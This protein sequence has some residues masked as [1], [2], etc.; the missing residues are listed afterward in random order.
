MATRRRWLQ[1]SIRTLLVLVTL[2]CVALGLW[3]VPAERQRRAV[4]AIEK[5]GGEVAYAKPAASETFPV[6][7]LR[8][9]LP[10]VYFDEVEGLYLGDTQVTD[11]GL[12]RLQGLTGLEILFLDNTP[13]TDA[14][15][16][17][18]QGLTTLRLLSLGDT[19]VTDAGLAHAQGLTGL[20]LLFLDN[21]QVTD[22]G[23]AEL[24]KALPNCEIH[25]P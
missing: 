3:C 24:H 19:Q 17:R 22:A 14:G 11:A 6:P 21:T 1:F 9:W 15:L 20:R 16:A 7:L 4:T 13:V 18:L 8:R 12:A 25:G 10:P 5:L 2:L 23:L